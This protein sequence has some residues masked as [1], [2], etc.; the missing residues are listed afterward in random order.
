M[1]LRKG[2]LGSGGVKTLI[3][4]FD[5]LIFKNCDLTPV[6][7]YRLPSLPGWMAQ[8]NAMRPVKGRLWLGYD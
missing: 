2:T 3:S 6:A 8:A 7:A 1:L 4:P 5:G